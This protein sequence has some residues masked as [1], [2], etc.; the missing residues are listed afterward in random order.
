MSI[1]ASRARRVAPLA[2][3]LVAA[4]LTAL[5]AQA[6]SDAAATLI[7]AE[8]GF[9]RLSLDSGQYT[10]FRANLDRKSV[11]FPP[12]ATDGQEWYAAHPPKGPQGVLFWTPAQVGV[13]ASGDL[14]FSTGPYR[15]ER[16]NGGDTLRAGGV[17]ASVWGR[18]PG[19]PWRVLV[20]LGVGGTAVPAVDAERTVRVA[21]AGEPSRAG[22]ATLLAEVWRADSVLGAQYGDTGSV[23]GLAAR[24]ADEVTLLRDRAGARWGRDAARALARSTDAGYRS[25]PLFG[26]VAKAGDLAYTY[27]TFT[28]RPDT[29]GTPPAAAE[30]GNYLR[31]WRRENGVWRLLLDVAAG[32]PKGA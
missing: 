12:R 18:R 3:L 2:A 6:P 30:A 20:D 5:G 4:P 8:R 10:A 19:E 32:V 17:F 14:G 28:R 27:G 9:A 16:V 15:Q 23:D 24:A 7:A 11:I 31:V 21:S 22:R 13:S 1:L 29:L 26:S 25:V